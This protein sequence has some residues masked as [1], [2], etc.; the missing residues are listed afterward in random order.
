MTLKPEVT[1]RACQSLAEQVGRIEFH[2]GRELMAEEGREEV[3]ELLLVDD[4]VQARIAEPDRLSLAEG[5]RETS[6]AVLRPMPRQELPQ[7]LPILA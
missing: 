4:F 5:A 7:A 2:V 6:G 3:I 1:V